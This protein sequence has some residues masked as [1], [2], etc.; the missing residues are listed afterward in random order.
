MRSWVPLCVVFICACALASAL[1]QEPD[2]NIVMSPQVLQ[3]KSVMLMC[4]CPRG[5]AVAE[6]TALT[7]LHIWGRF[8]LVQRRQDAD[9]VI[10]FSANRY[11]GDLLTRD[12][13]DTRPVRVDF[14]IMTIID[15]A[16]GAKIWTDWR[17][18]GSW[19]VES[20][21]H[22]LMT[23]FRKQI[24]EHTKKWT[25]DDLRLCSATPLYAGF[26]FQDAEKA[27][28]SSDFQVVRVP[29]TPDRLELGSPVAPDFCR[30]IQLV[31]GPD[32]KIIA[33]E[34]VATAADSLD[35]TEI[36]R[37]AD[38]FQFTGAKDSAGDPP[39]F[40]A[41][42]KDKRIWIRYEVQGRRSVLARVRF[43]YQ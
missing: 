30:Q 7:E 21:T 32:N 22:D 18:W 37:Y 20:A 5:L 42:S 11:L 15:A 27:L 28:A 40:T 38:T 14:T 16:T 6:S 4:E 24:E 23:E 29:G 8:Q 43:S 3:A 36:L 13:P 41:E 26:A 34:V 9:L 12:G 17:R 1:Q 31:I 2:V 35:L 10:L 39:Y 19:R 33:F 25:L